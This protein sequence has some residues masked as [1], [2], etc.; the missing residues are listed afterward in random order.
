[1]EDVV[2]PK[3]PITGFRWQRQMA[4]SHPEALGTEGIVRVSEPDLTTTAYTAEVVRVPGP[5]RRAVHTAF[6][7]WHDRNGR[8]YQVVLPGRVVAW[9]A[10]AIDRTNKR[11]GSR[12]ARPVDLDEGEVNGNTF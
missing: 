1:M 7:E 2:D 8:S 9:L 4:W 6:V 12:K 5:D 10:R 11:H 3:R